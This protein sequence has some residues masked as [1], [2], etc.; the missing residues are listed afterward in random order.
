M[1]K[2]FPPAP[3]VRLFVNVQALRSDG[4]SGTDR[5]VIIEDYAAKIHRPVV[6]TGAF[7][8]SYH[9]EMKSTKQVVCE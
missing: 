9:A 4:W 6:K 1:Q 3:P 2:F 8:Y 5:F 7:A